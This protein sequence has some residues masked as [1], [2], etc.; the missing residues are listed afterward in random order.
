LLLYRAK[1]TAVW[2]LPDEHIRLYRVILRID[3][4]WN[5]EL[6]CPA[7]Q[8]QQ[9]RVESSRITI[10]VLGGAR[11]GKRRGGYPPRAGT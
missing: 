2:K 6:R 4:Q 9:S 10:R 1:Q 7:W 5:I 11:L 8:R 3:Q